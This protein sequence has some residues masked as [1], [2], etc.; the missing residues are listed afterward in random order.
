VFICHCGVNIGGY[1]D[2]Q[3]VVD[4]AKTLPFVAYSDQNLYTCSVDAQRLLRKDKRF[5]L[6]R[7][8]WLPVSRTHEPLFQAVLVKA[9]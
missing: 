1:L 3:G 7:L 2:V 5:G 4:Y 6:N 9:G 8:W